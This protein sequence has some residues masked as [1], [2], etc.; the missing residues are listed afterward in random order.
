MLE[1][2]LGGAAQRARVDRL[3]EHGFDIGARGEE[4]VGLTVEQQE[5]RRVREPPARLLVA[6]VDRDRDAAHVGDLHVEHDEIG[7]V[8]AHR[9]L[10]VL[11]PGHLDHLLAGP[12]ERR[13]HL[14]AHPF[15]FGGNEDRGHGR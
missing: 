3:H 13:A 7:I 9:A 12:D 10:H 4:A 8:L 14:V 11:A 1:Q 15:G 2:R 5:D 6:Q